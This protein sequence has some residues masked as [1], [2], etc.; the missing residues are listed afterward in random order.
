LIESTDD[1]NRSF[2]PYKQS[3][4]TKEAAFTPSKDFLSSNKKYD[5]S[6][7]PW[8]TSLSNHQNYSYQALPKVS[9]FNYAAAGPLNFVPK[10]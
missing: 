6:S 5:Y 10:Q 3:Y 8:K 9:E 1:K 7:E 2:E 4:G